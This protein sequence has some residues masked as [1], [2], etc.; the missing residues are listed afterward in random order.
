MQFGALMLTSVLTIDLASRNLGHVGAAYN[1]SRWLLAGGIGLLALQFLLQYTLHFRA[2]GVTQGVAVNLVFF[3]LASWLLSLAI[4]NLQRRGHLK[5]WEWLMGIGCWLL[6]VAILVMGALADDGNLWENGLAQGLEGLV[7]G[8]PLQNTPQMRMAE[9]GAALVFSLMQIGYSSLHW[10]E[11]SHIKHALNNYYDGD[12]KHQ[13]LRWMEKSVY[14]LGGLALAAPFVIF[15]SGVV[16]VMYSIFL[17]GFI[18]YSVS[19]FINYGAENAIQQ[20]ETAEVNSEEVTMGEDADSLHMDTTGADARACQQAYSP[21]VEEAISEWTAAKGYCR[22]GLNIQQVADMMDIRRE[23]LHA[24]LRAQDMD[25]SAWL[26]SL[27]VEEAKRLL[28]QHP[29]L[30]NEAIAGDS[31]FSNRNY[32]QNV[33]KRLVGMTPTQYREQ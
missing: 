28:K 2:M 25:Y 26:N 17:I 10:K 3:M 31:G 6:G 7:R 12:E 8:L 24:W 29:E 18:Y 30:T 5:R 9:K 11:F 27:R 22:Q 16:L 33:F 21:Q 14:L 23:Q 13:L 19:R 1:R 32:F 20:V 15:I 4:L